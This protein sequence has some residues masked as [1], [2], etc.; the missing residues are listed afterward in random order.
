MTVNPRKFIASHA[1]RR[2]IDREPECGEK[3]ATG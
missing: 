3:I 2:K 1:G